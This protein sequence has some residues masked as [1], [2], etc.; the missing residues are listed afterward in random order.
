MGPVCNVI[1]INNKKNYFNDFF[2]GLFFLPK[3][4]LHMSLPN[5]CT[6]AELMYAMDDCT[7]A[8]TLSA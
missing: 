1:V 6:L 5:S 3:D 4:I 2:V 8:K 7:A